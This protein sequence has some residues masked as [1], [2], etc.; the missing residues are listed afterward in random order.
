[1]INH[2]TFS[3]LHVFLV[4]IELLI[5]V[6]DQFERQITNT[7]EPAYIHSKKA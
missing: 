7:C 3:T 4:N 6:E 5:H 2:Y 1:M